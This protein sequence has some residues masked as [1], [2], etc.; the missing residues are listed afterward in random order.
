M[1]IIFFGIWFN[2]L[3]LFVS[4]VMFDLKKKEKRK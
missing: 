2:G 1:I 3:W 4:T